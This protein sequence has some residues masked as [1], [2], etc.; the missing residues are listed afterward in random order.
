MVLDKQKAPFIKSALVEFKYYKLM[1][2]LPSLS[3]RLPIVQGGTFS[4][5]TPTIAI[6]SLPQWQ[7]PSTMSPTGNIHI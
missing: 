1:I 7:C 6:L 4:F 2:K 5:L 3:L